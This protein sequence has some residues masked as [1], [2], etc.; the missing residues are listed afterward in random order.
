MSAVL[1]LPKTTEFS[2]ESARKLVKTALDE[3]T[4]I[5]LENVSWEN[6]EQLMADREANGRRSPRFDYSSGTLWIDPKSKP[7]EGVNFEAVI[8]AVEI[9]LDENSTI[10]LHHVN[11]ETYEKILDER[12]GAS[13][14][15]FFYHKGKLTI[16]PTSLEHEAIIFFLELL[17]NLVTIEW[18]VNCAGFRSATFRREDIKNGFE[19]DSCF[20]FGENETKM[21]GKK[22][23]DGAQD[24]P[25]DLIIEVDITSPSLD[26]FETFREFGVPEI[27]RFDG[28][29]MQILKLEN[30][31]YVSVGNSLALPFVTPEKLTELIYDSEKIRRLEWIGKVQ[32]WAREFKTENE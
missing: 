22:R 17:I 27:W 4:L 16:M 32:T 20:Y 26:R 12:N 5:I 30:S 3:E 2:L 28:E 21:L 1:D 7:L 25:P 24:P 8:R 13:N 31:E 6:Y 11:W 15:R 14:P 10:V 19:P 23:F 9:S 29:K 18:Q